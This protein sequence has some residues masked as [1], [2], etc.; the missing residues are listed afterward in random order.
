MT[1]IMG[2]EYASGVFPFS[3]VSTAWGP[4]AVGAQTGFHRAAKN[5]NF[6]I[7]FFIGQKILCFE[8]NSLVK[9]FTNK[10]MKFGQN[11][12]S[13]PNFGSSETSWRESSSA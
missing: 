6:C 9:Q 3:A 5:L 8:E 13:K 2:I 7:V 11:A 1:I 10:I 4:G 12:K